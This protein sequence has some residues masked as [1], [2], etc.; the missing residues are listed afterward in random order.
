MSASVSGDGTKL[1]GWYCR[2]DHPRGVLLLAHG[3]AGHV[4]SRASWLRYLQSKARLSVFIFD[5][6]GYGRSEGTPT[7]EGASY[8]LDYSY[9]ALGILAF[10]VMACIALP[11]LPAE[12]TAALPENVTKFRFN[13]SAILIVTAIAAVYMAMFPRW[14]LFG[15]C[16]ATYVSA[17]A[18]TIYCW[19][20]FRGLRGRL[21]S[22][23]ACMYLPFLWMLGTKAFYGNVDI[24]ALGLVPGLPM[25]WLTLLI[26][27]LEEM[28]WLSLLL[29]ALELIVGIWASRYGQRL[30]IA[31]HLFVLIF[32][33]FA[34]FVLHALMRM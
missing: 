27:G 34:S 32:S 8:A 25:L 4:A 33:T 26:G 15:L 12:Q 14:F 11:W 31:Y 1:H 17:W 20:T 28:F 21:V 13:I 2:S 10:A 16:M 7:A 19:T 29:T 18:Y 6:R 30:A 9:T 24:E 5:Y 3:N 23:V 22:L